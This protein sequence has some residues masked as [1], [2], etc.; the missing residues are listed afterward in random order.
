M[1]CLKAD[2]DTEFRVSRYEKDDDKDVMNIGV[3]WKSYPHGFSICL[4]FIHTTIK[5]VDHVTLRRVCTK[6][7]W[8]SSCVLATNK[9]K[10]MVKLNKDNPISFITFMTK[11]HILYKKLYLSWRDCSGSKNACCK[12]LVTWIKYTE[13]I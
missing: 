11:Y 7:Y 13:P 4:M 5:V 1:S 10:Y 3:A 12:D 6:V 2:Y 8:M 9:Y